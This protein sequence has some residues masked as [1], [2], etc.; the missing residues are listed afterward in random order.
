MAGDSI[1][2]ECRKISLAYFTGLLFVFIFVFLLTLQ[3]P[4]L[5]D[6]LENLALGQPSKDANNQRERILEC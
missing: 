3:N 5:L 4:S 2:R 1:L 6:C